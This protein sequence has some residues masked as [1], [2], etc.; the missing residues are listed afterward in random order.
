M[1]AEYVD[2]HEISMKPGDRLILVTDGVWGAY[3]PAEFEETIQSTQAV[4]DLSDHLVRQALENGSSDNA[5]AMVL[6][7]QERNPL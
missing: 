6:E 4:Q 2:S 1:G 3:L 5:T 7:Y